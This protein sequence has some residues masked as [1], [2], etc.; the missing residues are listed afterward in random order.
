MATLTC[1]TLLREAL[2]RQ[3]T[4]LKYPVQP[5]FP[6]IE[7]LFPL[8]SC[9]VSPAGHFSLRRSEQLHAPS[10]AGRAFGRLLAIAAALKRGVTFRW[11]HTSSMRQIHPAKLEAEPRHPHAAGFLLVRRFASIGVQPGR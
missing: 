10:D 1:L 11:L 2:R 8:V 5:R 4:D 7:P 6:R 9:P 3:L